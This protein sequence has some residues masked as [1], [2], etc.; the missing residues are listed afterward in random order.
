[1]GGAEEAT[2]STSDGVGAH[3]GV[4]GDADTNRTGGGG[5]GGGGDFMIGDSGNYTEGCNEDAGYLRRCV[6]VPESIADS[7]VGSKL[8]RMQEAAYGCRLCTTCRDGFAQ[9]TDGTTCFPC[10]ASATSGVIA[11]VS[12]SLILFLFFVVLIYLKV[13]SSTTGGH[14]TKTKAV[15]S[16][17]KRILLTHMQVVT[18]CVSL[19]VPWPSLVMSLMNVFSSVSSVSRYVVAV[20]LSLSLFSDD[21]FLSPPSLKTKKI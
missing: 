18:L 9:S 3:S 11:A 4:I 19:N 21:F 20:S 16:T 1:L 6:P 8:T 13:A 14:G 10:P 2:T 15:H 17:I 5:G 7:D 12:I